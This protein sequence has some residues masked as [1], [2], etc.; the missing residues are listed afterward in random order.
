MSDG[1]MLS[2][3]DDGIAREYDDTYDITIHCE[4]REEQEEVRKALENI[5]RW[6]PCSEGLP[7]A[8]YAPDKEVLV[9]ILNID[10]C[11]PDEPPFPFVYK[12]IEMGHYAGP[13]RGWG[14][15]YDYKHDNFERRVIAWMPLPEPYGEETK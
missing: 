2:I 6:I 14:K 3:G 4:S 8:P 12:T 9:C 15:E 7:T 13:E 10:S 1:I 5:P 11:D